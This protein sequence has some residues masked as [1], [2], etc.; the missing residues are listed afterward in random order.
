MPAYE[1]PA[2][3]PDGTPVEV[4][5]DPLETRGEQWVTLMP[6]GDDERLWEFSLTTGRIVQTMFDEE[7][8]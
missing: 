2:T 4:I 8:E 6:E 1:P 7:D 5:G 3:V